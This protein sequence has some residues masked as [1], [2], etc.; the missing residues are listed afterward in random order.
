[1][2]ESVRGES[3]DIFVTETHNVW[4]LDDEIA[5]LSSGREIR[6]CYL[7]ILEGTTQIKP[8]TDAVIV[9]SIRKTSG[10]G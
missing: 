2:S 10:R 4:V 3:L 5:Y 9:I 8:D 7:I 1:M 6:M